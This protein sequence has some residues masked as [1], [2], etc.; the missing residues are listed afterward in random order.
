MAS[1]E[2][3]TFTEMVTTTLRNHATELVDNVSDNNAFLRKLK[4]K[5][6]IDQVRRLRNRASPSNTPKTAPTSVIPATTRS[7]S[8]AS[9]VFTAAKYDWARSAIHVTASGRELRMNNGPEQMINLVKARVKNAM[10]T[11][12]NNMS[13]DLYSDGTLT[14]QIG[15]LGLTSSRTQAPARSA[16][17]TPHR[18]VLEEQ[19]LRDGRHQHLVEVHDQGRDEQA[20]APLRPRQRQAGPDRRVATTS[21]RPTRSRCRT[22]SAT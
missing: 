19:V 22:C 5:G 17:S 9:D 3:A 11:A 14:N 8:A 13:V 21:T 2:L 20:L 15:G 1:S 12:A 6:N 16:A 4:D 18:Y 10:N 7:T